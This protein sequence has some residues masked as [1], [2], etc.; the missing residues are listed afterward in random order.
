MCT[1]SRAMKNKSSR[2]VRARILNTI[3]MLFEKAKANL[4]WGR[5]L[6][7]FCY[8]PNGYA[9]QSIH[10][11]ALILSRLAKSGANW[12]RS[13]RG[14]LGKTVAAHSNISASAKN[15]ARALLFAR[16]SRVHIY[17]YT[18]AALVQLARRDNLFAGLVKV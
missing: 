4:T 11:T 15:A 12:A 1:L 13:S 2:M 3:T 14:I 5:S 18:R 7:L 6:S 9:R 8:E 16:A 10:R 17:V